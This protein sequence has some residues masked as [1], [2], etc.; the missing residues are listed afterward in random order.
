MP[1]DFQNKYDF[2]NYIHK[3][4][5]QVHPDKGINAH[6]MINVNNMVHHVID[7]LVN[8]LDTLKGNRS[9]LSARDVQYAIRLE[10]GGELAKH[11]ISEGNKA[12]TK[13]TSSPTGE[14]RISRTKRAGLQFSPALAENVLRYKMSYDRLGATAPVYMAAVLEYLSAEVLELAGN[15]AHDKK[16]K[17]LTTRDVMLGVR[18]DE[19]LN[20]LFNGVTNG[21]VLPYINSVLLP[22]K[23]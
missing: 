1:K 7:K 16:H 5:K 21:G 20:K 8:R 18:Y 14:G 3:V 13:F 19:E 22:K 17:Y 23:H 4:L 6:A 9:V 12:V 10:I 11:A 2:S 15:A